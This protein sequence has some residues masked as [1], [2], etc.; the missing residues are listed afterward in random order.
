L[1]R[2]C[3]RSSSITTTTHAAKKFSPDSVNTTPQLRHWWECKTVR[4]FT[5]QRITCC[6]DGA[7]DIALIVSCLRPVEHPDALILFQN[8]STELDQQRLARTITSS[9]RRDHRAM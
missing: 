3:G 8:P 9:Q 1:S 7:A 6:V 2:S 4:S 5:S